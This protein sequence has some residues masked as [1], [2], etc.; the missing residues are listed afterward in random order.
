MHICIPSCRASQNRIST[1][2]ALTHNQKKCIFLKQHEAIHKQR[3]PRKEAQALSLLSATEA[4]LK[5]RVCTHIEQG[6][7]TNP[8]LK[9]RDYPLAAGTGH[10]PAFPPLT[11][12]GSSNHRRRSLAS[13]TAAGRRRRSRLQATSAARPPAVLTRSGDG[14]GR[15]MPGSAGRRGA[16]CAP[17]SRLQ[18]PNP[19]AEA[20]A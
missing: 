14:R 3:P 8:G 11:R 13:A 6:R 19:I 9:F 18:R 12:R 1:T 15:R 5:Q 17:P 4:A 2:P 10:L 16:P 20:A 7:P